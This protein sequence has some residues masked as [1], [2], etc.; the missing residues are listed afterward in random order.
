MF[1]AK[2]IYHFVS[3]TIGLIFGVFLMSFIFLKYWPLQFIDNVAVNVAR[4]E[5]VTLKVYA[6]GDYNSSVLALNQLVNQLKFYQNKYSRS[7]KIKNLVDYDLG[8]TYARLFN[9]YYKAGKKDLADQEYK[10]AVVLLGS[11]FNIKS[12]EELQA[13]VEQIDA[14]IFTRTSTSTQ[15]KK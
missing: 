7:E 5:S 13:F 11:K 1:S 15:E 9:V 6:L 14:Q 8:L 3:W 2:H 12:P 10:K 4:L